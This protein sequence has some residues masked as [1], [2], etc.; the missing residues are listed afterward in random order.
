MNASQQA[1]WSQS[2]G[3]GAPGIA[4]VDIEAA[5]TGAGTWGAV[6]RWAAAMTRDPVV[7][8]PAACG[9]FYGAPAVAFTLHSATQPAYKTMLDILDQHIAALTRTRLDQAHQRID[10]GRLPAL[11][12]FDLIGGLTGIGAYLLHRHRGGDLLRDVLAYLV[13]LIEPV[14]VNGE[15]LPGWWTGDGPQGQPSPSWPGGHGNLGIAHGG[16]GILAL[17]A[18]AMRHG[19]TVAGQPEALARICAQLDQ[20]RTG[21]DTRAWWPETISLPEWRSRTSRQRGAGRPSWCYGT[22]GLARAQQL[23]ALAIDDT[24][25]QSRAEAAMAGCLHNEDQLAQ[26]TDASLCHGWAGLL[27]ATERISADS[28]SGTLADLLPGLRA[29]LDQHRRPAHRG[30]LEGET[31]VLL[32]QQT[33]SESNWDACLL[34]T[35]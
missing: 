28:S 12:E 26:I 14:T 27:R 19:T 8:D 22:P 18:T 29:R 4:L 24:R 1:D 10:E 2:L 30:F 3:T 6:H 33:G 13:R 15:A 16:S 31:G 21:T 32:A 7:A 34:L 11:R 5:R 35:G 20:W 17:M 9:L 23:A 25:L